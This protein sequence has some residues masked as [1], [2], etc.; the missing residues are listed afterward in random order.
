[1]DS[2]LAIN[3]QK[4]AIVNPSGGG[5]PVP[6]GV[7]ETPLPKALQT[8]NIKTVEDRRGASDAYHGDGDGHWSNH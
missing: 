6:M 3:K 2:E 7:A 8:E 5:G 4:E 1:M